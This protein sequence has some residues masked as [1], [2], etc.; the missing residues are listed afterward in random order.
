MDLVEMSKF[1]PKPPGTPKS[2]NLGMQD[3]HI[4]QKFSTFDLKREG[5][6][7][8]WIGYLKPTAKSVRYKVKIVYD[9]YKPKVYILEPEVL[10]SSP[11]R[12]GDQSLCLYH[13]N[14]NSFDG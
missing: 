10:K 8:V 7:W 6:R 1:P 5:R 14:D 4:Q 2:L 3:I 12:Y 13:P 11:H 9:P